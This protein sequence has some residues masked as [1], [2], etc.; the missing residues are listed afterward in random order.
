MGIK[1]GLYYRLYKLKFDAVDK[2][3]FEIHKKLI[4]NLVIWRDKKNSVILKKKEKKKYSLMFENTI[5]N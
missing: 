5:N 3:R 2:Y 1:R 4:F